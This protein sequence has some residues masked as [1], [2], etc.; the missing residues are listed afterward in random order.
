MKPLLAMT[1]LLPCLVGLSVV[2]E[3]LLRMDYVEQLIS[4]RDQY[5]FSFFRV[6]GACRIALQHTP[7]VLVQLPL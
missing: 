6:L 3:Y 7:E 4:L 2:W 5:P 1:S